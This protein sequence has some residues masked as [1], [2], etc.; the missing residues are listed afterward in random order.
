SLQNISMLV[1]QLRAEAYQTAAVARLRG[2]RP[3]AGILDARLHHDSLRRPRLERAASEQLLH[4]DRRPWRGA[5]NRVAEVARVPD[6]LPDR[7][8]RMRAGQKP[9][10]VRGFG[11]IG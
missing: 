8:E 4:V 2:E 6:L 10:G 1:A 9:P 11:V 3:F 7:F 5:W